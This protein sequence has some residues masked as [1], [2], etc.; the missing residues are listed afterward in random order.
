MANACP[1]HRGKFEGTKVNDA[2]RS[3]LSWKTDALGYGRNRGELLGT[4]GPL[5][6]SDFSDLNGNSDAVG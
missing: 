6:Y 5:G 3:F 4:T 1:P 2:N